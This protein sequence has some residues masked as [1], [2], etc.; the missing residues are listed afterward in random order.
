MIK[1]DHLARYSDSSRF[2]ASDCRDNVARFHV[3]PA[4][5]VLANQ[6]KAVVRASR[7]DN[8]IV[9]IRKVAMIVANHHSPV[10]NGMQ[11][12]HGIIFAP[13]SCFAGNLNNVAR[14]PEHLDERTGDRIIVQ[15]QPHARLIFAISWGLRILGDGLNL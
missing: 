5:V 3:P 4:I 9:Q 1:N 12:M 10:A 2:N 8:E 14:L 7:F 13:Q 11:E 6:K 15:V